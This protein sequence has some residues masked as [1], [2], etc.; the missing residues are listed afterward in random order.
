MNS[1]LICKSNFK[2]ISRIFLVTD[3]YVLLIYKLFIFRKS[4]LWRL[5]REGLNLQ[6]VRGLQMM[7]STVL[8]ISLKRLIWVLLENLSCKGWSKTFW[9]NW[10]LETMQKWSKDVWK[11]Q[12]KC[13]EFFLLTAPCNQP[14]CEDFHNKHVFI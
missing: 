9:K 12:I 4:C 6:V 13:S 11:W 7:L 8:S 1:F 3:I 14:V 2:K 10:G 5:C